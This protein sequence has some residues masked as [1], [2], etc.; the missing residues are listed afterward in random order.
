MHA[1][2]RHRR[3]YCKY[4]SC[5]VWC[6]CSVC[7]EHSIHRQSQSESRERRW[8]LSFIYLSRDTAIYFNQFNV[9]VSECSP[10]ERRIC[11]VCTKDMVAKWVHSGSRSQNKQIPEWRIAERNEL[12]ELRIAHFACIFNWISA[13]AVLAAAMARTYSIKRRRQRLRVISI[14]H[15]VFHINI[16]RLWTR[17][18]HNALHDLLKRINS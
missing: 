3:F 6:I 15:F 11:V 9:S 16:V 5:S 10:R 14:V 13:F 4:S 8:W 12:C 1:L 17:R 18:A 2:E 7:T